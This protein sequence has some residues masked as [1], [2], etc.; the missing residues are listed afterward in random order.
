MIANRDPKA[1][2]LRAALTLVFLD[3]N[4]RPVAAAMMIAAKRPRT[5]AQIATTLWTPLARRGTFIARNG[6]NKASSHWKIMEK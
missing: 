2:A 1:P 6:S 4:L 3:M 5:K